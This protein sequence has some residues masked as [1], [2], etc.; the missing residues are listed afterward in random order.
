MKCRRATSTVRDPTVDSVD[1]IDSVD[2]VD[3]FDSIDSIDS[4]ESVDSVT[5]IVT[6]LNHAPCNASV[7]T[8]MWADQGRELSSMAH[9]IHNL[10]KILFKK[11]NKKQVSL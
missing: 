5:R 3:S 2:S 11:Q 9:A 6:D 10:S 4:V 7:V 1:S 8:I